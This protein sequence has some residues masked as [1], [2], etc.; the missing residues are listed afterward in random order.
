V[1]V[2]RVNHS[3]KL[4]TLQKAPGE[5]ALFRVYGYYM[6]LFGNIKNGKAT[7]THVNIDL[8]ALNVS[9]EFNYIVKK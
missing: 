6:Y 7:S 3:I 5:G 8:R 1:E 4:A 2:Y 9:S